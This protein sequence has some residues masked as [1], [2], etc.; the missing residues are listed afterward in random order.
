MTATYRTVVSASYA[1]F[2]LRCTNASELKPEYAESSITRA[3]A[4][5]ELMF[6][7]P[8][9]DAD[10]EV[11][12][13]VLSEPPDPLDASWKDVVEVSFSAGAQTFLTGWEQEPDDLQLPLPEGEQFRMRY[14]IRDID[15][16]SSS[17][18]GPVDPSH[19]DVGL[20]AI[21]IWP[22]SMEPGAVLVQETRGGR[23][24]LIANGLERLRNELFGRK[25]TTTEEE[26]VTEFADRAFA[27]YPDLIES[28]IQDNARA[29]TSTAW[30]LH[31][32]SAAEITGRTR[33]EKA[34]MQSE[35][36]TRISRLILQR[37]RVAQGSH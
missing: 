32:I 19:P 27:A 26:R 25:A 10:L 28:T 2:Y 29:L 13:H 36:M 16:A 4:P 35:G 15:V 5:G 7:S 23:Y 17:N 8:I 1:Q 12:V 24:W 33:E 9:Q 22:H 14:A 3:F 6:I 31:G 34:E 37:A 11:D 18:H 30:M 21:D 20:I